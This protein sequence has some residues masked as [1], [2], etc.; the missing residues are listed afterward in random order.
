MI[1]IKRRFVVT[2]VVLSF[3][4]ISTPA[5]CSEKIIFSGK[6]IVRITENGISRVTNKLEKK[7]SLEYKC[8]ITKVDKQ[9]LWT[10]RG[11][12]ELIRTQ[13]GAF[14]TFLAVNGSG[15][16]RILEESY[17]SKIPSVL[18]TEKK[19]DYVEHMMIGLG[20]VSYY[21]VFFRPKS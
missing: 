14:I 19:F 9:Y 3:L 7:Q 16:I 15:Y 8:T 2:F 13:S 18:T 12:I 17:K 6:P 5:F 11:N 10:T 20:T 1:Q 4:F 21:G